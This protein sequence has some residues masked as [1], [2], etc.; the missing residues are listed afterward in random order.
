MPKFVIPER[1]ESECYFHLS[2]LGDAK[3]NLFQNVECRTSTC[4]IGQ[5]L[6]HEKQYCIEI[7]LISDGVSLCHGGDD[8]LNYGC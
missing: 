8:E 2:S 5:Y 1:K 6:C 3:T 7:G 4:P